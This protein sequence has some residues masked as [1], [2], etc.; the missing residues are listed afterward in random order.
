M[1]RLLLVLT[2]ALVMAAMLVVTAALAFAATPRQVVVCDNGGQ[3]VASSHPPA[4]GE[5]GQF[6][7]QNQRNGFA[8]QRTPSHI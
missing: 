5:I 2:V 6:Q 1:R 3:G 8:C 7:G 4:F